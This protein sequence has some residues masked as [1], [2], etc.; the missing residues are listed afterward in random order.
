MCEEHSPTPDRS[1][2][3][4][5]TLTP[6]MFSLLVALSS[7]TAA[8]CAPVVAE[9][10]ASRERSFMQE[11]AGA[12]VL[13]SAMKDSWTEAAFYAS[14][15]YCNSKNVKTWTC[16]VQCA[17]IKKP[18]VIAT[19]G[20]NQADP[21]CMRLCENVLTAGFV[22][23]NGSHAVVSIAGTNALSI[24]SWINDIDIDVVTPDYKYFP[25]GSGLKLHHGFYE[26][27]TRLR[28]G[29]Q[30]AVSQ[31]LNNGVSNILVV[32]HSQGGFTGKSC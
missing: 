29:V 5:A 18:T 14:A 21:Y 13:T 28:G 31:A 25:G 9:D 10:Q 24:E 8:L 19:G 7:A 27:F 23:N 22:V 32:G 3:L 12:V 30:A 16:G 1:P 15:A 6:N 17:N 26:T 20:D 11:R 2:T 4:T